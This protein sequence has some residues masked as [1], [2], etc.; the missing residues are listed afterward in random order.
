MKRILTAC[1]ALCLACTVL[2]HASLSRAERVYASREYFENLDRES[3]LE[4]IVAAAGDYY[5]QGSG[6]F[7]FTWPLADGGDAKVVFDSQGRIVMIYLTGENGSEQIYKREYPETRDS[8]AAGDGSID[9]ET[10]EELWATI[11]AS[12]P[13]SG[14]M[15][16]PDP[17]KPGYE[18]FDVTGDGCADLCTCVTWGS[19]MVRTDL[20]VYDPVEKHLYVLDGYNY[21]Y[22]IDHVEED[23]IVIACEGPHGYNDPVVTTLGTVRIEDGKLV[24]VPD[25][26]GL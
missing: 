23:K 22:L 17:T 19:G 6:I 2:L 21:D 20:T 3:S 5:I 10:V 12:I 24:F 7:Y 26:E 14:R 25:I 16:Y 9:P 11:G 15:A 13:A 8:G 4:D 18:L 1:L